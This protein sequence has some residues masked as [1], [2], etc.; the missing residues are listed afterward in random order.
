M[1]NLQGLVWIVLAVGAVGLMWM[2][3]SGGSLAAGDTLRPEWFGSTQWSAN[4][5]A[6][7]GVRLEVIRGESKEMLSSFSPFAANANPE[8]VITYFDDSNSVVGE[9]KQSLSHRC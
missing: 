8:A 5:P 2:M 3:T 1:K 4:Q 7:V 9:E 6:T